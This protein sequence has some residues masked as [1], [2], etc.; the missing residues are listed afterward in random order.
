MK[1][2]NITVTKTLQKKVGKSKGKKR[3]KIF[4]L[5]YFLEAVQYSVSTHSCLSYPDSAW[6]TTQLPNTPTKS[7]KNMLIQNKTIRIRVWLGSE[8][9][10]QTF[11]KNQ[12]PCLVLKIRTF[13][14]STPV[15]L[16][17]MV[18]T[19]TMMSSTSPVILA[20]PTS[21]L[22]SLTM[23]IFLAWDRG[24]AISAATSEIERF[25]KLCD[26]LS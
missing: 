23:V 9:Y 1:S 11:L 6:L 19:L 3:E 20:A 2:T 16:L 8:G 24:A 4:L 26:F 14:T 22:P 25:L 17:T 15:I 5:R 13:V 18:G 10:L 7:L 12:E 21:P